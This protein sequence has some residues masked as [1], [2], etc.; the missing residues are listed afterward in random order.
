M[1]NCCIERK[2]K[3]EQL[4]KGYTGDKT[5]ESQT[6]SRSL[7]T[8]DAAS[9]SKTSQMDLS[10]KRQKLSEKSKFAK[11]FD[12]ERS[13][14]NKPKVKTSKSQSSDCL[15][16]AQNLQVSESKTV[17]TLGKDD[18]TGALSKQSE[19]DSKNVKNQ[20]ENV[21]VSKGDKSSR[22][23]SPRTCSSSDDEFY[24]CDNEMTEENKEE[25]DTTNEDENNEMI[26]DDIEEED[27]EG[28]GTEDEEESETLEGE[29]G[30]SLESSD[31]GFKESASQKAEGRMAPFGD[32]K[33]LG[34]NE[35]MYIPLTQEPAPMTEDMLDEHAEILARLGTSSEGAQIRARMQS[36][37]LVSDMESFKVRWCKNKCYYDSNYQVRLNHAQVH[38]VYCI[39]YVI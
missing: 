2:I 15:C 4:Y 30:S 35:Q 22:T 21:E 14:K 31:A 9:A 20:P 32:L 26:E 3:R 34:S 11:S 7:A 33:S 25:E 19:D 16:S 8:N 1:L 18:T 23:T 24:E 39:H 5:E 10:T 29:E 27:G 13:T 36:A 38:L 12:I 28:G 6:E 17:K 37:C